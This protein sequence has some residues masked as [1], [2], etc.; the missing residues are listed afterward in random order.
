MGNRQTP[1]SIATQFKTDREEPCTAQVAI[2]IP[3]S[4]K[5]RLKNIDNWQ[6]QARQ[7]LEKIADLKSA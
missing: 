7:A 6:E 1:N 5:S 4:L 2:R 3:P